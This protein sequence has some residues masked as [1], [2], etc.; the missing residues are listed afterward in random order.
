MDNSN[1]KQR[2]L[3]VNWPW[4]GKEEETSIEKWNK[5]MQSLLIKSQNATR[6]TN[7]VKARI[8]NTQKNKKRVD[9][10]MTEMKRLI[11]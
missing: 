3:H 11:T 6:R 8:D 7:Y 1:D 5:K 2:K 4:H 9:Y 10:M